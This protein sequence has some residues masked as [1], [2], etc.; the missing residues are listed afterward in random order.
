MIQSKEDYKYYI[1]KDKMAN[2]EGGRKKAILDFFAGNSVHKFLKILRKA[3]YY[4]NVQTPFSRYLQYIYKIRLY[5]I[6]KKLGYTIP[7]NTCGAG[8][9]LPHY[10]PI[11]INGSARIGENCRIHTCV[12][13]GASGGGMNAPK[14]G[15]NVYIGP[16]AVIFG[17]ISI[18]NN[19]TIGANATVNKSCE[20]E[21]V[22]LAG[23]PAKIVKRDKQNWWKSN[24][25]DLY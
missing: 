19:V 10:G 21:N 11:I 1:K 20:E 9:S 18:A 3:E 23:T 4:T 7:C 16:S 24:N 17:D 13:I 2:S 8:L 25:L 14:I 15:D 12:N 6:S 5:V 22:A